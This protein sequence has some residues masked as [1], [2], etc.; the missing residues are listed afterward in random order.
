MFYKRGDRLEYIKSGS[1]FR[2]IRGDRTVE[3][4]QVL[5]VYTDSYGIPH[6][7]FDVSFE[8]PHRLRFKDGPRNLAL[9]SFCEHYRERV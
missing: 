3:T 1:A 2:R 5:A 6:V 4:A 9:K 8:K 7:R